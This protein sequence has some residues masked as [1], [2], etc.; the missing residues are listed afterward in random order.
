M[1]LISMIGLGALLFILVLG[2]VD[3]SNA[4]GGTK[5]VIDIALNDPAQRDNVLKYQASL[6]MLTPFYEVDT[7]L[8]EFA[9]TTD[10]LTIIIAIILSMGLLV[11][12][13]KL[14]HP[15]MVITILLLI[16]IFT[17]VSALIMWLFIDMYLTSGEALGIERQDLVD[18]LSATTGLTANPWLLAIKIIAFI[19]ILSHT[20]SWIPKP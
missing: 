5:N 16:I 9:F 20:W 12:I 11:L 19:F 13:L 8:G 3:A 15:P 10:A 1:G 2:W 18:N 6:A 7:P 14:G 17:I 4:L